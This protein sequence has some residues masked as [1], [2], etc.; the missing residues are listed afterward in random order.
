MF[1]SQASGKSRNHLGNMTAVQTIPDSLTFCIDD[2]SVTLEWIQSLPQESKDAALL[3]LCK[4][5][6]AKPTLVESFTLNQVLYR[7]ISGGKFKE[8]SDNV[9][10]RTGCDRKTI[11]KGLN[12]AV[13]QNILEKNDRPGTSTE[14]FF[15][16]VEEWLP[17]P[18]RV[19]QILQEGNRNSGLDSPVVRNRDTRTKKIIGFPLSQECTQPQEDEESGVV[20]TAD[21]RETDSN[22]LFVVSLK[23]EQQEVSVPVEDTPTIWRRTQ[24][25]TRRSQIPPIYDQ[26]T[27][28]EIQRQMEL[29]GLTAQ[30]VVSRAISLTKVPLMLLD[31][32]ANIGRALANSC[33]KAQQESTVAQSQPVEVVVS[34]Q[35]SKTLEVIGVN[36][37][38]RQLQKCLC[39]Y[40]EDVMLN[41][42]NELKRSG[43]LANKEN[44]TGYFLGCLKNGMGQKPSSA[45]KV[46]VSTPDEEE[47]L[48]LP[49]CSTSEMGQAI[50]KP[51]ASFSHVETNPR[52]TVASLIID[53]QYQRAAIL[54]GLYG[55]DY[56]ELVEECGVSDDPKAMILLRK[57]TN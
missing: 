26:E 21:Y 36:L 32:L 30:K 7:T 52:T 46:E 24:E 44:P 15:K 2:D 17:Q 14:Y 57:A 23:E 9:A 27:G 42:A 49:V 34:L 51:V 56:Q 3:R 5:V 20:R 18:L 10:A 25:A 43:M 19:R 50:L 6:E 39:E 4:V 53:G 35:L 41:A 33:L 38:G 31:L 11:L 55:V 16:P 28:V 48:V 8:S 47:Q 1:R 22:M 12:Q 37:S 54:A 40:G 45:Q 13:E 29:E